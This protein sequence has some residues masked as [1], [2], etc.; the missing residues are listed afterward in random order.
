MNPPVLKALRHQG[1][2]LTELVVVIV[3]AGILSAVIYNRINV[4]A[5]ST[6]GYRDEVKAAVRYAHKLAVAQRRDVH[7][8]LASSKVSLCYDSGCASP[9]PKPPGTDAFA[10]TPPSG[11]TPAVPTAFYFDSLGRPHVNAGGALATSAL[12]VTVSGDVVRTVTIE[13]DTGFVH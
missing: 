7:V 9:V 10:L 1:F 5:F 6:D 11:V 12:N 3:I 13:P 4:A 8:S 2:T